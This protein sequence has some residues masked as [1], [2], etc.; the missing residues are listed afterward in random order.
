MIL[1][2]YFI[3]V[4]RSE[5]TKQEL[6]D[7]TTTNGRK[8]VRKEGLENLSTRKV[9][10]SI[11]YAVGTIYN[12]YND[13]DDLVIH[14]NLKTLNDLHSA[15]NKALKGESSTSSAKKLK[16]I[17]YAYLDFAEKN[18]NLWS[19]IFEHKPPRGYNFPEKYTKKVEELFSIIAQNIKNLPKKDPD[20]F[21]K[22][23]WSNIHGICF[24]NLNDKI[25]FTNKE[26]TK[27]MID[28]AIDNHLASLK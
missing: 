22:A 12:I 8:I 16:A 11:G 9:S 21:V 7:M 24:L 14:V 10:D 13:R 17:A 19:A 27:K 2:N 18:L 3:M 5:H 4:R 28:L 6:I 25:G 20:L 23:L 26:D 1:I 15:I